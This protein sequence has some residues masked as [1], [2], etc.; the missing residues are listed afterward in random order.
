[1]TEFAGL[2]PKIYFYLINDDNSDKKAKRTQKM[3]NKTNTQV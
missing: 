1:M 2:R 3:C